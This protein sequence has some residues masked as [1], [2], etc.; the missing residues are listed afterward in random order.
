MTR[1][2]L[3][4][5]FVTI[6]FSGLV[7][8][9]ASW[10]IS[11]WQIPEITTKEG[12][13]VLI[14]CHIKAD[15]RVEGIMV[16]WLRDNQTIVQ[17]EAIVKSAYP[18]PVN[19]SVFINATLHLQSISLNHSGMY[20]CTAHMNVPGLGTVEYGNGTH[21]YA[22]IVVSNSSTEITPTLTP[23][24]LGFPPNPYNSDI[25]MWSVLSGFGFVLLIICIAC[26]IH[27]HYKVGHCRIEPRAKQALVDATRG[28]QCPDTRETVVYAALNIPR[29]SVKSR[30]E[31]C[32]APTHTSV[33]CTEESV[34][35]SEVHIKKG[36]KDEG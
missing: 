5:L 23:V 29:D 4:A 8:G 31:N 33:S 27:I 12:T 1:T 25:V 3:S 13:N 22:A 24:T 18:S 34:T 6:W 2:S 30:N 21:V 28:S 17:S 26:V 14:T 9:D 7:S 11:V 16:K 35:Y 36:P 19:G 10:D 20:Y 15:S 32:P